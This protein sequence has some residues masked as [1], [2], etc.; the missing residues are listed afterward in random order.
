MHNFFSSLCLLFSFVWICLC[1]QDH[2]CHL[3]YTPLNIIFH[4]FIFNRHNMTVSPP[5]LISLFHWI[6]FL[7]QFTMF[8]MQ[9]LSICICNCFLHFISHA[10]LISF[11]RLARNKC[12]SFFRPVWQG[13]RDTIQ[14]NENETAVKLLVWHILY[15]EQNST[16]ISTRIV[17]DSIQLHYTADWNTTHVIRTVEKRLK[18]VRNS[19]QNNRNIFHM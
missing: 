12:P 11:E 8:C 16:N 2:Y 19:K 6:H 18:M 3:R 7:G 5:I 15:N 14:L 4:S 13:I 10:R 17:V 9:K 1:L